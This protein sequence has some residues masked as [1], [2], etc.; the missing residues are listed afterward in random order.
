MVDAALDVR[1]NPARIA[2]IPAA[3]ERLGRHSELDDEIGGE[4]LGLDLPAFFPPEAK[5]GIVVRAHDDASIG[6]ADKT[7]AMVCGMWE[8]QRVHV[9]SYE[10]DD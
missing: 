6:A 3:I 5:E 1:E 2:L 8:N 7:A 4:V 10:N 9:V